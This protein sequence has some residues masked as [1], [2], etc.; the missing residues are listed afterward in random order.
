MGIAFVLYH[1]WDK[2]VREMVAA[3]SW[4]QRDRPAAPSVGRQEFLNYPTYPE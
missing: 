3:S 1:E 4:T 2:W